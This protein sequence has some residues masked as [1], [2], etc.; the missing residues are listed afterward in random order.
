MTV[1]SIERGSRSHLGV[2]DRDVPVG[3]PLG[4]LVRVLRSQWR[5]LATFA[6]IA[7]IGV[8]AFELT[9][10]ATFTASASFVTQSGRTPS[11]LGGIAAQFGIAVPGES[12]ND[13]PQFY[14][15]LLSSRAILDSIVAVPYRIPSTRGQRL[16]SLLE[17]LDAK[18]RSNGARMLD[19]E[20][21]L[22]ERMVTTIGKQTGVVN[23]GVSSPNPEL[24]RA[25]V[26]RMLTAVNE[27]NLRKR[28]SHA[29]AE[30]EFAERQLAASR[31]ELL[32]A[33]NRLQAFLQ[34]NRAYRS[35]PR[36]S[37]EEDRLARDVATRQQVVDLLTQS[38]Q[39]A[40]LDEVRDTPMITILDPPL[41]P[42]EADSRGIGTKIVFAV[43]LGLMLG[44]FVAW[45]RRGSG[46]RPSWAAPSD[47]EPG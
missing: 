22:R 38:Y 18:G 26:T 27:F 34:E 32:A 13:S 21:A 29:R 44:G 20:R 14:V 45:F 35:S 17:V 43:V 12:G 33:E 39:R 2:D 28:Q 11:S 4:D 24:S 31:A 41:L 23:L 6:A 5:L 8:A 10:P 40:R 15:D 42:P 36:L 7:A 1:P 30:R 47:R 16:V 9:R 3:Q 25:I 19:A 37:F 46:D